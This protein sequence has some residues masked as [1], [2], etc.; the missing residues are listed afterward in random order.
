MKTKIMYLAVIATFT[1]SL[2]TLVHAEKIDKEK[3][4]AIAQYL[5]VAPVDAMLKDAMGDFL[6]QL[7]PE[8][9]KSM[10]DIF[11]YLDTEKITTTMVQSMR[12]NLTSAEIRA[13]TKF[14][15]SSDGKSIMKKMGKVQA[16]IVPVIQTEVMSAM[17]KV[18]EDISKKKQE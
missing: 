15:S 14:Y 13:L 3:D 10:E 8:S 9:Q 1:L 6:K 17:G 16:E 7:P 12:H 2:T 5:K 11:K 18:L 4:A